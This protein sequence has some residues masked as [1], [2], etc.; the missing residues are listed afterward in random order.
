MSEKLRSWSTNWGR[1]QFF[2]D[3]PAV[4]YAYAVVLAKKMV[5]LNSD[6]QGQ[7]DLI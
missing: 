6:A 4:I 1:V 7:F 2:E 3:F 5:S